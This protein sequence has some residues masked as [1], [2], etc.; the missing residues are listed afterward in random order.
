[1]NTTRALLWKE[2]KEQRWFLMA[3]GIIF[4]IIPVLVIAFHLWISSHHKGNAHRPILEIL[5]SLVN[6][7]GAGY[8]IAFGGVF[9]VF[10]GVGVACRDL[11][12]SLQNFWRSRPI[13]LTRWLWTKYVCGLL[14][15]LVSCSLLLVLGLILRPG[16]NEA[17]YRDFGVYAALDYHSFTLILLYSVA[18][19]IGVLVR[20]TA[21]AAILALGAGL[22]VY[23]LPMILPPLA[24]LSVFNHLM[25]IPRH[26]WY[27]PAFVPFALTCLALSVLAVGFAQ[28]ALA[29][30]KTLPMDWKLLFWSFGGVAVILFATSSYQLGSNLPCRIQSLNK[31][32]EYR[33][34][35]DDLSFDGHQELLLISQ[36][37]Q[38]DERARKVLQKINLSQANPLVG[39]TVPVAE[40]NLPNHRCSMALRV[41]VSP[42]DP[43]RAYVIRAI[44]QLERNDVITETLTFD[45]L[46]LNDTGTVTVLHSLALPPDLWRYYYNQ[47]TAVRY[48]DN[49]YLYNYASL[50]IISLQN[51]EQPKITNTLETRIYNGQTRQPGLTIGYYGAKSGYNPVTRRNENRLTFNS[52][53]FPDL[54]PREQLDL[55]V[56]LVNRPGSVHMYALENDLLG[57]FNDDLNKRTVRIHRLEKMGNGIAT[58]IQIGEMNPTP[59]ERIWTFAYGSP[60]VQQAAIKDGLAYALDNDSLTVYDLRDPTCP[61]RTGHFA[62]AHALKAF[63]FLP[64][65]QLALGG[66]ALYIL[67][68]KGK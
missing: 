62:A 8:A 11:P 46:R 7:F 5:W 36:W 55:T 28:W 23:F 15:L 61:R 42:R 4:F 13:G 53:P 43:D 51:P 68:T 3:G 41:F 59:L 30:N 20:H 39:P 16:T 12:D 19:L 47:F 22:V 52:V 37:Q 2:W 66:R 45:T 29:R 9:A 54:T 6:E 67:S 14:V 26:T 50:V 33:Q 32:E 56:R 24:W 1:M 35:V 31:P 17:D 40:G 10:L 58:F 49:L 57:S 44:G 21:Q 25:E 64:D 48:K 27:L 34:Y 65:H 63:A 38:G 18:F 60:W